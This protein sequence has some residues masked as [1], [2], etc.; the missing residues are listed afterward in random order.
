MAADSWGLVYHNLLGRNLFIEAVLLLGGVKGSSIT[1]HAIAGSPVGLIA[2]GGTGLNF[3]PP[4]LLHDGHAISQTNTA[5]RYAADKV[6]LTPAG[7]AGYQA[8]AIMA[9]VQDLAADS[10]KS[11]SLDKPAESAAYF[12]GR[13]QKHLQ[14]FDAYLEAS[15]SPFF[16]GL[17]RPSSADVVV[18]C[19][20]HFFL[21]VQLSGSRYDEFIT[22]RWPKLARFEAAMEGLA[23]VQAAVA[24]I[25]EGGRPLWAKPLIA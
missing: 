16:F 12:A 10:M 18:W 22:A 11:A 20:I 13:F 15:G 14:F 21:R 25:S 23:E 3:A 24:A 2:F 17:T 6:G 7:V 5:V 19:A 9:Q 8:D 4:V 1:R